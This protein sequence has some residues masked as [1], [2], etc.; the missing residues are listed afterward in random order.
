[1]FTALRS[2]CI[3]AESSA[4]TQCTALAY[5]VGLLIELSYLGFSVIFTAVRGSIRPLV[6]DRLSVH[7]ACVL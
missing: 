3:G 1:M 4:I 5:T 2:C 7:H 6:I